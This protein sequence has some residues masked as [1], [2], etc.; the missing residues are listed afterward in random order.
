MRTPRYPGTGSA[1][2]RRLS[3]ARG[4]VHMGGHLAALFAAGLL[5]AFAPGPL[6]RLPAQA[7][8]GAIL[9]FLFAPLH[10]IDPSHRLQEPAAQRLGGGSSGL[11]HRPAGGLLPLLPFRPSPLHPES[12]A[13]SRAGLAQAAHQGR[14]ALGRHGDSALARPYRWESSSMPRAGRRSP[15]SRAMRGARWSARR[16]SICCSMRRSR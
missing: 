16:G 2:L 14:L 6:W 11:P 3:D 8:E 5:V 9:I 7:L 1:S 12:R 15:I 4:L 10:E 13:R